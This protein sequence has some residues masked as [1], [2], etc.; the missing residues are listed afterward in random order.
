MSKKNNLLSILAISFT[1]VILS[2]CGVN[3]ATAKE[4]VQNLEQKNYYT[5]KETFEEATNELSE[6]KQEKLNSVVAK[7]V[8]EYLDKSIKEMKS[9]SGEEAFIYNTLAKIKEIGIDDKAL[10]EKI[11]SLIREIEVKEEVNKIEEEKVEEIEKVPD[12]KLATDFILKLDDY[13]KVFNQ[14]KNEYRKTAFNHDEDE[15]LEFINETN[16]WHMN[17][18]LEK[19]PEMEDKE[20]Q[21]KLEEY[22]TVLNES[23]RLLILKMDSAYKYETDRLYTIEESGLAHDTFVVYSRKLT[24]LRNE[25]VEYHNAKY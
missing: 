5:A 17:L 10:D 22:Y 13:Y 16:D 24:P 4:I 20:S 18:Q 11:E 1:M 9:D 21:G 15:I 19:V 14:I 25:I 8:K 7:S 12:E 23:Y 2:G 3:G 6:E